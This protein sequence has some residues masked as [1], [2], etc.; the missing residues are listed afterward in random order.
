MNE[1]TEEQ[2][3]WYRARAR[4]LSERIT[5]RT[6]AAGITYEQLERE[7]WRAF[8]EVS[9]ERRWKKGEK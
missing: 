8:L 2:K 5:M 1:L 9:R 7:T 3:Q 4:K 6:R